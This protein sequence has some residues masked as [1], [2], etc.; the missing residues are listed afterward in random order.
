MRSCEQ[1]LYSEEELI[2]IKKRA[3]IE[4][5]GSD[6]ACIDTGVTQDDDNLYEFFVD[7]DAEVDR[8]MVLTYEEARDYLAP[9]LREIINDK[10]EDDVSFDLQAFIDKD[11]WIRDRINTFGT[12]VFARDNVEHE[13]RVGVNDLLIYRI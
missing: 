5:T 10:V 2:D 1:N 11:L 13:V 12:T 7:T 9:F 6:L 4:F 8:F 3:L